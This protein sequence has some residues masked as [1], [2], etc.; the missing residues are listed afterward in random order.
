MVKSK[1]SLL[2]T[3]L[4]GDVPKFAERM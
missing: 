2:V 3:I 4:V 1:P